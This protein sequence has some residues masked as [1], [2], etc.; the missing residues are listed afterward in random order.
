MK[1][2]GKRICERCAN[3]QKASAGSIAWLISLV[4]DDYKLGSLR[5]GC[6]T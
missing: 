2:T 5:F 6:V 1:T 4:F 3:A